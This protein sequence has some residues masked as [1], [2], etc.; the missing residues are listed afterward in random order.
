VTLN[1]LRARFKKQN[2]RP[3]KQANMT[4]ASKKSVV[5]RYIPMKGQPGLSR[6][7][8]YA[9]YPWM[10]PSFAKRFPPETSPLPSVPAI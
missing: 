3:D 10:Q 4:T 2:A 1:E 6:K 7:Q 8:R 5:E 9:P